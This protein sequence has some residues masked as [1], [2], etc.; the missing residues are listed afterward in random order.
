[1]KKVIVNLSEKT[2]TINNQTCNTYEAGL[3]PSGELVTDVEE[4]IEH[5]EEREGECE[6]IFIEA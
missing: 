3:E 2:V 5:F 6:V 4:I 1:M